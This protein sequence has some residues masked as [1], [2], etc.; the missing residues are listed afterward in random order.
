MSHFVPGIKIQNVKIVNLKLFVNI[1][2]KSST[3]KEES[4]IKTQG[5]ELYRTLPA[6]I[7]IEFYVTWIYKKKE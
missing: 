7:I 4:N 5:I 6:S 1:N 3:K 2:N